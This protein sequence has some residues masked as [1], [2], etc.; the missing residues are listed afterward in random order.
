M[1]D[2]DALRDARKQISIRQH[3]STKEDRRRDQVRFFSEY[4]EKEIEARF[5][6][7]EKT[8]YFHDGGIEELWE[9][10][11]KTV[12]HKQFQLNHTELEACIE[13][14]LR[15]SGHKVLADQPV[16]AIWQQAVSLGWKQE[17]PELNAQVPGNIVMPPYKAE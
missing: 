9:D 17:K 1:F 15:K 7:H 13:H 5:W 12:K 8:K 14:I 3:K 4:V 2:Q 11:R 10:H 6:Q 16:A